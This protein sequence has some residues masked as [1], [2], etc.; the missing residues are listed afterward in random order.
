[1][2]AGGVTGLGANA[3]ETFDGGPEHERVTG[4]LKLLRE[5]T[6]QVD[7]VLF[8]LATLSAEGVQEIEKSGTGTAA[9]VK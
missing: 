4:V 8:P 7:A 1:M 6:V 3:Q 2:F 5:E 9:V